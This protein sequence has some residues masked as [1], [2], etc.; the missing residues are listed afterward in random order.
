MARKQHRRG[1]VSMSLH[2]RPRQDGSG[3]ARTYKRTT[4]PKPFVWLVVA[5]LAGAL[6]EGCGSASSAT[7]TPP[8]TTATTSQAAATTSPASATTSPRA[9]T[10]SP[11]AGVT[12]RA[13]TTKTSTTS[14]AATRPPATSAGQAKA[15]GHTTPAAKTSSPSKAGGARSQTKPPHERFL[16]QSFSKLCARLKQ[17]GSLSAREI[18]NLKKICKALGGG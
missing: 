13:P 2:R 4:R 16:P 6:V 3:A 7:S 14:A 9:V 12:S 5:L 15:T 1:Y 11:A 8:S 17:P 18:T 10:T